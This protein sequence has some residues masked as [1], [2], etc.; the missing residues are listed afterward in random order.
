M[1]CVFL[2]D[3]DDDGMNIDFSIPSEEELDARGGRIVVVGSRPPTRRY[4]K[5]DLLLAIS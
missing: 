1:I 3:L 2:L 5:G 4:G